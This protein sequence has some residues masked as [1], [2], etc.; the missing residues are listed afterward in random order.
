MTS[1]TIARLILLAIAV[2][3]LIALLFF[4]V[5]NVFFDDNEQSQ[6]P[7][8]S[9]QISAEQKEAKQ[10]EAEQKSGSSDTSNDSQ[11]A[12]SSPSTTRST[13]GQSAGSLANTGPGDVAA[14]FTITVL[15]GTG[16][17]YLRIIRRARA[18]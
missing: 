2:I 3:A 12:P 8:T 5:R 13:N 17:S 9:K 16:L 10:K 14:I 15:A 7:T 4:G 18:S 1:T 11:S 6:K